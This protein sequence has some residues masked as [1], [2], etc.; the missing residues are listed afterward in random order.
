MK[1]SLAI[2]TMFAGLALTGLPFTAQAV[3][4]PN[5]HL[6]DIQR[7]TTSSVRVVTSCR[8]DPNPGT[9]S[10]NL[11]VSFPELGEFGGLSLIHCN[12]KRQTVTVPLQVTLVPNTRAYTYVTVSGDSGEINAWGTFTV[13]K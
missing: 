6:L 13:H 10:E 3:P 8:P 11:I 2:T 7:V 4:S 5:N 1:R 9:G 12:G